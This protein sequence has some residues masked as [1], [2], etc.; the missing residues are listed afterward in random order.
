MIPTL[1][2]IASLLICVASQ[3]VRAALTFSNSFSTA[4]T[5]PSG[6]DGIAFNPGTGSLFV[7]D[8]TASTVFELTLS[9]QLVNSFL[10][11]AGT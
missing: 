8:S 4:G 3:P 9:G 6:P 1:M 2:L 7:V 10:H 5:V 11:Q